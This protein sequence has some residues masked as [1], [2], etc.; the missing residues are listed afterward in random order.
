MSD[1]LNKDGNEQSEN[2]VENKS[3]FL[4]KNGKLIS[5]GAVVIALGVV[6]GVTMLNGNKGKESKEEPA[7]V[8]QEEVEKT[9]EGEEEKTDEYTVDVQPEVKELVLRPHHACY[10]R[11]KLTCSAVPTIL[12]PDAVTV[13]IILKTY[14]FEYVLRIAIFL[15]GFRCNY[16]EGVMLTLQVNIKSE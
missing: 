1:F 16:Q 7:K 10:P 6:V 13:S 9:P 11:T 2:G 8:Q 5:V 15:P 4:K 14:Y 3:D 12:E